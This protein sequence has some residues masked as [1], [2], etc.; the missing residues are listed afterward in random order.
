LRVEIL[1][2]RACPLLSALEVHATAAA[3]SGVAG[4]K[5]GAMG[6]ESAPTAK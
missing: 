3:K 4:T 5:A 2:A 6:A 1:D